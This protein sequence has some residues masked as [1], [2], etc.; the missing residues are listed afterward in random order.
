MLVKIATWRD[1][2][3]PQ[4]PLV[5]AIRKDLR[6]N[7]LNAF[8]VIVLIACWL[9]AYLLLSEQPFNVATFGVVLAIG[10]ITL[11][12][13]RLTKT[14]FALARYLFIA[15]LLVGFWAS[16]VFHPITWLPMLGLPLVLMSGLLVA[17][18]VI[19]MG[20]GVWAM[21]AL[22]TGLGVY[23][24]PLEALSLLLLLMVAV[25][26][27]TLDTFYI[28][29]S[30][31]GTMHHRA[32][33]LLA[34][35]R[36]HRAELLQTVKSLDIS[37]QTQRH[38]Q[39][40]LIYARQQANEARQL[41]ERFAANISHELRTP[42]NLILGFSDLMYRTPEVY[43]DVQFPPRLYRDIYQI[44]RSS[45]HLLDMIDD[46]L[47]LSHIDLSQ[48]T[49][50]FDRT[51]MTT[52]LNDTVEM[53]QTLF[54]DPNVT[55]TAE[56]PPN[57]PALNIDKTRIRQ[58]LMNLLTN[59]RRFT[60]E[61]NVVLRVHTDANRLV[62][63]VEDTGIGIP[64]DKL[65]LIFDEFYQVDYSLSRRNG[66]AGLGL[67]ISRR[68]VEAHGGNILAES[69]LGKGSLFTF[70]LPFDTVQEWHFDDEMSVPNA[71]SRDCVLVIEKDPML[72]SMVQRHLTQYQIVQVD[73]LQHLEKAIETYQPTAI[74]YNT[75]ASHVTAP[76]PFETK[77]PVVV[78]A[79][80]G[81]QWM[82]EQLG[83]QGILAKPITPA[84]IVQQLH[85][86]PSVD[87]VLIVDDDLGFVQL[88]QR[89][90]ET[91]QRPYTILRAYDGQ[92]ALELMAQHK[93][94]LI[95]LDLAMPEMS[96]FDV[97]STIKQDDRLNDMVI[98]LLTATRK[99]PQEEETSHQV[100]LHYR[101]GFKPIDIL[102][103]LN[104]LLKPLNNL[105]PV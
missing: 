23:A 28:A 8:T 24:Y 103:T 90:I 41:K 19:L 104:T 101:G 22:L 86:Y 87:Y 15:S 20:L 42:L 52:F 36:D 32:D 18:S 61:G 13:R 72:I 66:G 1:Q 65:A 76:L 93:P 80:H 44:Y 35:A 27:A 38:M 84:Q 9:S 82:T 58:V 92:Q 5:R 25:T 98:I 99:L 43:G 26:G 31:Y 2:L 97:L 17:R 81:S 70:T 55:F 4:D 51:H 50:H 57:L 60:E 30:W 64:S 68:F 94:D 75:L 59:A 71:F 69:T 105:L 79:L 12:C 74:I 40:Q 14:H 46:V 73:E 85:Q 77:L 102:N 78:C 33:K 21:P 95:F 39:Q 16:L 54:K 3:F 53:L 29:L 47:D 48:F 34:E 49:L 91:D 10:S 83:V 96:G 88:V 63:A 56:I 45:R 6:E 100:L 11:L 62:F 67:T 7:L 37:Y 89:S